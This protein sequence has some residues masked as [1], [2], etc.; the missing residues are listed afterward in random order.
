MTAVQIF[1][2]ILLTAIIAGWVILIN[3]YRE[4][5]GNTG[6]EVIYTDETYFD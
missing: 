1:C 4:E 2:C 3:A 5:K 6:D